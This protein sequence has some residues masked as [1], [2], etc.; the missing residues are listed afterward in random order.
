MKKE[1]VRDDFARKRAERQRKIRKRRL[2]AFF[3]FLVI[4]MLCVGVVLSF[5]VFFPIKNIT[6][7]GSK[8]YSSEE[9]IKISGIEAGDNLFAVN[10]NSA[11]NQLKKNLPYIESIK[12]NRKYRKYQIL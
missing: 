1:N 4:L 2:T 5:T 10:E 9:I 12:F 8:I 6:V 3:V 7:T 11:E